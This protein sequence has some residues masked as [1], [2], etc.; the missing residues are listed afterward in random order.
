MA[1]FTLLLLVVSVGAAAAHQ[2]AQ[3]S[4]VGGATGDEL[5]LTVLSSTPAFLV[6]PSVAPVFIGPNE[7]IQVVYSRAVVPLG[8]SQTDAPSQI[9]FTVTGAPAGRVRWL[10]SY[11]ASYEPEGSWGT[12]VSFHIAWNTELSTFDGV[13]LQDTDRLQVR[14]FARSKCVHQRVR[15]TSV[16]LRVRCQ[17]L[18]VRHTW[19][20]LMQALANAQGDTRRSKPNGEQ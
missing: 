2:V 6:A 8:E 13:P 1:S 14:R 3:R 18:R 19:Q 9:P 20:Y 12:D 17:L 15:T 4:P 7:S 10:N 16:R 5:P 11:V